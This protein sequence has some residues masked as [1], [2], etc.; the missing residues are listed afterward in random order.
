[1]SVF[2]SFYT[3]S[4]WMCRTCIYWRT[5]DSNHSNSSQCKIYKPWVNVSKQMNFSLWLQKTECCPF[6]NEMSINHGLDIKFAFPRPILDNNICTGTC[7]FKTSKRIRV[8]NFRIFS[9]FEC[10]GTCFGQNF[11]I[12][13]AGKVSISVLKVKIIWMLKESVFFG[14]WKQVDELAVIT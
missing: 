2:L 7:D 5:P 11:K 9:S 10:G 12:P 14:T 13:G 4:F 1:M 6:N 3:Y 8:N